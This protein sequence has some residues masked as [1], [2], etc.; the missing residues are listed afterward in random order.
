[1]GWGRRLIQ[2][3]ENVVHNEEDRDKIAHAIWK[4]D[5]WAIST[6]DSK[7]WDIAIF[8]GVF[9]KE[10][11]DLLWSYV[12]PYC[13][14]DIYKKQL[15]NAHPPGLPGSWHTDDREG[16]MTALYYPEMGSLWPPVTYESEGGL[17]IEDHGII[18]Y[19]DNSLLIF[20]AH[21][22]HRTLVHERHGKI[23]FSVAHKLDNRFYK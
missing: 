17:E 5:D 21:L 1:M 14:G 8:V 7:V 6:S 19:K 18:E 13:N 3:I 4:C 23:R 10:I 11:R 12:E 2:Q 15:I 22:K 9:K 16:F 20:P